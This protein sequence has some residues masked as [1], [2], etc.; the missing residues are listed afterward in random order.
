VTGV[1]TLSFAA[2]DYASLYAEGAANDEQFVSRGESKAGSW[3]V[4]EARWEEE[5]G[6]PIP[7]FEMLT[8]VPVFTTAAYEALRPVLDGRGEELPIEVTTPPEVVAFNVTRVIDALD[9]E[10]SEVKRFSSGRVM[11]VARPAFIPERVAGETIFRITTYPRTIYVTDAFLEAAD[12]IGLKGMRLSE[13]WM[14]GAEA[15][16]PAVSS[17]GE[18]VYTKIVPDGGPPDELVAHHI[19]PPLELPSESLQRA[20]AHAQALG[21]DPDEAGNGVAL[22]RALHE[23]SY[24]DSYFDALWERFREAGD[25]DEGVAIL[26]RI[27]SELAAGVFPPNR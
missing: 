13:D 7:D 2:D 12:A 18:R 25:R 15:T 5:T 3:K 22:P 19:I 1:R 10:R 9:E 23:G 6:R 21:I 17:D 14:A 26:Q 4:Y 8:D 11:R 16:E 24:S 20:Q 27:G